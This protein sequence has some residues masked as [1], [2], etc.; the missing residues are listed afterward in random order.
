MIL[1][2]GKQYRHY[3]FLMY[4]QFCVCE[5][6]VQVIWL[7]PFRIEEGLRDGL[8]EL[9]YHILGFRGARLKPWNLLYSFKLL[10]L[11]IRLRPDSVISSTS[12]AYHSKIVWLYCKIFSAK[13]AL[14]KEAWQFV[15]R[16]SLQRINSGMTRFI[17]YFFFA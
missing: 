13:I 1:Y 15:V 5:T 14:R 17:V 10:F 9:Q 6:E 4:R 8:F 11:L 2:I 3:D 16:G 12:D 7:C